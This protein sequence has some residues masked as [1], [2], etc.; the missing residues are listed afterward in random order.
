MFAPHRC[1]LSGYNER[2]YLKEQEKCRAYNYQFQN[3][4]AWLSNMNIRWITIII[5]F[6]RKYV[7]MYIEAN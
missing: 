4:F 3:E 5:H 1:N 7:N 2:D 6:Y